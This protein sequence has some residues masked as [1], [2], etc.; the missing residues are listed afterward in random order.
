MR[1]ALFQWHI[2]FIHLQRN[3]AERLGMA[4]CHDG[5]KLIHTLLT[6]QTL[7]QLLSIHLAQS[8]RMLR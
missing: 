8:F 2:P 4:R 1:D 7:G 3:A 6:S 5:P